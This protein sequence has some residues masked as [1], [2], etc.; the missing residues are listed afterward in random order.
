MSDPSPPSRDVPFTPT[1]GPSS[2]VIGIGPSEVGG[3]VVVG[4]GEVAEK[5]LQPTRGGHGERGSRDP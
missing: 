4:K 5:C 1:P 2:S 3:G